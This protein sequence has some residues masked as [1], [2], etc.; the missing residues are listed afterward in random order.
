MSGTLGI[1]QARKRSTKHPTVKCVICS[2][3]VYPCL[4]SGC[5]HCNRV[6]VYVCIEKEG[7]W[8]WYANFVCAL[9]FAHLLCFK[10]WPNRFKSTHSTTAEE[11]DFSYYR[12]H[13]Y[14]W[15]NYIL[16][17]YSKHQVPNMMNGAALNMKGSGRM[18]LHRKFI[19]DISI[20]PPG[21]CY[22]EALPTTVLILCQS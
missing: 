12:W 13:K 9:S 7:V 14:R 6:Y 22:S 1:R 18:V 17:L 19:P 16:K 10:W 3:S 15:K 5:V 8:Q 4:A 11:E 21:Y 20:A 2:S